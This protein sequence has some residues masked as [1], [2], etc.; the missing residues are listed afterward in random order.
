MT[1]EPFI[2]VCGG[3]FVE[4]AIVNQSLLTRYDE[5]RKR[6]DHPAHNSTDAYLYLETCTAIWEAHGHKAVKSASM[7]VLR[8]IAGG[9]TQLVTEGTLL[10]HSELLTAGLTAQQRCI[11]QI[12]KAGQPRPLREPTDVGGDESAGHPVKPERQP[13]ITLIGGVPVDLNDLAPAISNAYLSASARFN[14][15]QSAE[16]FASARAAV[17]DAMRGIATTKQFND[18]VARHIGRGARQSVSP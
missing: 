12:G 10:D 17:E 13:N 9:R 14:A 8:K 4:R 3:R 16:E 15:A 1:T 5:A 11:D 18:A 2:D 7:P 6:F